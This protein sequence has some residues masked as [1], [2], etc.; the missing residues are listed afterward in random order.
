MVR[1]SVCGYDFFCLSYACTCLDLF[2][3]FTNTCVKSMFSR[4][5]A[6]ARRYKTPMSVESTSWADVVIVA[7]IVFLSFLGTEAVR[8]RCMETI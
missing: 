8:A 3:C 2:V 5:A 7:L 6:M 4:Y 1:Y